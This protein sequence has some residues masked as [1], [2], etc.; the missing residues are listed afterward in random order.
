MTQIA[1]YALFILR[2][3]ELEHSFH[4]TEEERSAAV[5]A[6]VGLAG[7][8]DAQSSRQRRP[9]A[10]RS[11]SRAEP[12][13]QLPVYSVLVRLAGGE[14]A[15]VEVMDHLTGIDYPRVRLDAIVLVAESD[16]DTLAAVARC[17]PPE[18]VRM[19]RI[20]AEDFAD[21]IV[22]FDHGLALCCV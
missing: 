14:P 21:P 22:A 10:R 17:S 5:Q 9:A 12:A 20:P 11:R 2:D 15:L 7:F 3:G 4:H 8:V 13:A 16:A 1:L 6:V 18:W 19:A